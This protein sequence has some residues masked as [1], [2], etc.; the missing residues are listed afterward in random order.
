M[1]FTRFVQCFL[2]DSICQLHYSETT[3]K[4]VKKQQIELNETEK[5]IL[6]Y[7]NKGLVEA[8]IASQLNINV[9]LVKYY[10]KSIFRKLHVGSI[11]E[12]IYIVTHC[13][14]I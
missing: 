4:F 9:N 14:I 5:S 1:K 8:K 13:G 3:G 11:A 6:I 12:T 10:K 2:H 7:I